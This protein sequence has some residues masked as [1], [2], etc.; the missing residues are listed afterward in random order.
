VIQIDLFSLILQMASVLVFMF[1]LHRVLLKPVIGI[2]ESRDKD[3]QADRTA[4]ETL[5]EQAGAKRQ[6][7]EAQRQQ[8][9]EEVRS[10]RME[11]LAEANADGAE[12]LKAVNQRTEKE[13]E[14]AIADLH[15][16]LAQARPDLEKE[17]A[18]LASLA[19]RK[20]LA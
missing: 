19:E 7:V 5:L 4:A 3:L 10:Y 1:A 6:E 20:L 18:T 15:A 17:A 13:Y 12:L 14:T 11:L 2:V 8:V 16:D 9:R